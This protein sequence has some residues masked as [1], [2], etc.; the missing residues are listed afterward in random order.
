MLTCMLTCTLLL[1]AVTRYVTHTLEGEV[2]Q[3]TVIELEL[4]SPFYAWWLQRCE[5]EWLLAYQ[6]FR[7]GTSFNRSLGLSDTHTGPHVAPPSL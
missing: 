4:V 6:L 3:L 1:L 7:L 2:R 5:R